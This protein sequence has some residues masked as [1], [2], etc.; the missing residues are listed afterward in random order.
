M[1]SD[2]SVLTAVV[3]ADKVS[4]NLIALYRRKKIFKRRRINVVCDFLEVSRYGYVI[5]VVVSVNHLE[6]LRGVF[7]NHRSEDIA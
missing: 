4:F 6:L 2:K 5:I 7:L 1:F 3:F